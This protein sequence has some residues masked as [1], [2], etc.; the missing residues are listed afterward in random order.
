MALAEMTLSRG[1][2]RTHDRHGFMVRG[3]TFTTRVGLDYTAD[4]A[5]R[6]AS[7][8]ILSPGLGRPGARPQ[9]QAVVIEGDLDAVGIV[10]WQHLLSALCS[11][12]G[13]VFRKPLSQILGSSL[14]LLQEASHTRPFGG[15]GV[16]S[17]GQGLP[18]HT[19]SSGLVVSQPRNSSGATKPIFSWRVLRMYIPPWL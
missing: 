4:G 3:G 6:P 14:L 15:L 16:T 5:Y 9:V 8:I 12:V 18:E 11:G 7:V 10:L 19:A 1:C 2:G 13:F 17:I